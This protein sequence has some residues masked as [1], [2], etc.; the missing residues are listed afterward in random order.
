MEAILSSVPKRS[1]TAKHNFGILFDQFNEINFYVED[2]FKENFYLQIFR[3]LFPKIRL[4]RIIGLGGKTKVIA[5]AE[6]NQAS[7]KDIYILDQD[8]DDILGLK[9]NLP[10]IFY[11][12][13]YCIENYLIEQ[14]AIRNIVKDEQTTAKAEQIDNVFHV[15][16]FVSEISDLMME[17]SPTFLM[18]RK[19]GLSI[20]FFDI[21]TP[22]DID[23]T[24][25]PYSWKGN[26][27][28]YYKDQLR[29][30]FETKNSELDY[31]TE[32]N[33]CKQYFANQ[34]LIINTPGKYLLRLIKD[35]VKT[36]LGVVKYTSYESFNY[37]IGNHCNLTSLNFLKA[38]VQRFIS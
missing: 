33:W 1:S 38:D 9:E 29:L 17:V 15:N 28:F 34:H 11:L 18:V 27:L 14:I 4:D 30:E 35:K 8:F 2:E 10:N 12:N 6:S 19:F 5:A 24:S 31:D 32:Y 25:T 26:E 13:R 22:R 16:N 7:K 20:G 36:D 3:K 23:F 37:R 21:N